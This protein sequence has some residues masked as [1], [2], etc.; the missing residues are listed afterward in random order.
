MI[1]DEPT[2]M[3]DPISRRKIF[4]VLAWLKKEQNTTII[5]IEHSLENLIPLADC[6]VLMYR[7]ELLFEKE[8]REFFREMELLLAKDVFPPGII[9]FYNHLIKEGQYHG[10]LPLT[11]M[12]AEAG[13]RSWFEQAGQNGAGD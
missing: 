1:L 12:E 8:T 2:S 10:A 13:L 7:G 3:L 6:M 4:D 11:V 9:S 5:V